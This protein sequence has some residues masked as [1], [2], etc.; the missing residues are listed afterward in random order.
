MWPLPLV[1]VLPRDWETLDFL[2]VSFI[3]LFGFVPFRGWE[4]GEGEEEAAGIEPWNSPLSLL[5]RRARREPR[6]PAW[7]SLVSSTPQRFSGGAGCRHRG[8]RSGCLTAKPKSSLAPGAAA[9]PGAATG[10][11]LEK[12]LRVPWKCPG[13]CPAEEPRL[14]TARSC[15]QGSGAGRGE[16]RARRG[17][18]PGAAPL[19]PA[20]RCFPAAF[21]PSANLYGS[22]KGRVP[23]GAGAAPPARA[24]GRAS[25]ADAAHAPGSSSRAKQS[26]PAVAAGRTQVHARSFSS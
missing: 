17:A 11:W 19:A 6:A 10:I 24:A 1:F 12:P 18:G 16:P 3:F 8:N 21:V 2:S 5:T 23:G 26:S 9:Q 25:P 22:T 14:S 4:D 7:Q 20:P 15:A 13:P